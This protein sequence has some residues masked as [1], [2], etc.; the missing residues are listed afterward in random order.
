METGPAPQVIIV[1]QHGLQTRVHVYQDVPSVFAG[2]AIGGGGTV[3]FFDTE[4]FRLAPVVDDQWRLTDL[5]VVDKDPD[6]GL[7]LARLRRAVADIEDFVHEVSQALPKL[8]TDD[9]AEAA[10]RCTPVFGHQPINTD[11]GS[12]LHNLLVH[13]IW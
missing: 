1:G 7:V 8:D 13:G 11:R 2:Q 6:P 5:R 4:G 9:L 12:A 3:E 10:A